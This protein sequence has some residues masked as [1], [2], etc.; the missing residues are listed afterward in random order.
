MLRLL[1]WRWQRARAKEERQMGMAHKCGEND[2]NDDC[3]YLL[4]KI[5][6]WKDLYGYFHSLFH[7]FIL[8]VHL[9]GH[10]FFA[11]PDC[12]VQDLGI[13]RDTLSLNI[14]ALPT[15]QLG[16]T[17]FW[18][19]KG[20]LHSLNKEKH[21]KEKLDLKNSPAN[22]TRRTMFVLPVL[23]QDGLKFL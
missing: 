4:M 16:G 5:Y 11:V 10:L 18:W 22:R 17:C 8:F 7:F 6:L 13:E 9:F 1:L 2:R 15:W 3:L 23:W 19:F 21:G 12:L 14:Q 20:F